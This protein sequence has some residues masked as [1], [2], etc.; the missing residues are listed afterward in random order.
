MDSPY[1]G[2]GFFAA[3]FVVGLIWYLFVMAEVRPHTYNEC[4]GAPVLFYMEPKHE[5]G[6]RLTA[7]ERKGPSRVLETSIVGGPWENY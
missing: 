2:I 5:S 3:G 7:P 4:P 1:A 6:Q